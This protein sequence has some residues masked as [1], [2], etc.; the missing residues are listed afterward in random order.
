MK[1]EL[2]QDTMPQA[3]Y[4]E[5]GFAQF[6][7]LFDRRL[8]I[9]PTRTLRPMT[10][11]EGESHFQLLIDLEKRLDPAAAE[12]L[13]DLGRG[14]PCLEGLLPHYQAGWLEQYH[15]FEVGRFL[16]ADLEMH[17]MEADLGLLLERP[18]DLA[19]LLR[20]LE[21]RTEN[22]FSR[23][24]LSD[25][26]K[27]HQEAI[28]QAE[29]DLAEALNEY[30]GRILASTG[31]RMIY[32]W[33]KE[34]AL[35]EDMLSRIRRCDLVT[36]H[37]RGDI[38]HVD[39]RPDAGILRMVAQRDSQTAIFE[40]LM[41]RSLTALNQEIAGLYPAFAAYYRTRQQR[42]W[43]YLLIAVK[44]EQGLCFPHLTSGLRCHLQQAWLPVLKARKD[45][46]CIPLDL[47]LAAGANVLYGA[48]MS[49]KT[50]VLKTAFCLF[51]LVRFGLPAP[52][53]AIEMH[54]PEHI[55]LMLKSSGNI[56]TDTST[57]SEELDFFSRP[58]PSKA[59]VLADELFSSTDP[60]NGALLSDIF[61]SEFNTLDLVFF[62]TSHYPEVL[63]M[64]DISLF[65]M[66][67]ID[68]QSLQ[69]G[70]RDIKTLQDR[71]PY[72]LEAI[73]DPDQRT[74]IR[75]SHIPLELALLYELPAGIK[76]RIRQRLRHSSTNH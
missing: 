59:F 75:R 36:V 25:S 11:S 30:E 37:Q 27:Q 66:L 54:F 57:F 18:G 50:T 41:Q 42:I 73:L 13:L 4:Q 47:S 67:D 35:S 56:R 69:S 76:D 8:P 20:I 72:R 39:F 15:L 58:L 7:G 24:R 63:G 51:T 48:N 34:I 3:L 53:R 68:P 49:G 60:L 10:A 38:W 2:E 40:A 71:M 43:Q 62:C 44:L 23:L 64:P 70:V 46:R 16:L 22:T 21:Q 19:D 14:L 17:R 31:L 28:A 45:R 9:L 6:L 65:R 74:R 26:E 29:K 1:L 55:F 61:L 5:L 33:P 52:A 32:P 12:R